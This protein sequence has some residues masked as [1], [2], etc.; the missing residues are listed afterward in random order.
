MQYFPINENVIASAVIYFSNPSVFEIDKG[1][2]LEPA[3][4]FF[5]I[6]KTYKLMRYRVHIIQRNNKTLRFRC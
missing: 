2:N 3:V 4:N 5:F 1:Q 6:G